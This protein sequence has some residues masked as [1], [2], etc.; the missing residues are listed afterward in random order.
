MNRKLILIT[1]TVALI[2]LN[3]CTPNSTHP[4]SEPRPTTIQDPLLLKGWLTLYDQ[5]EAIQ[6][7]DGSSLSGR[8]LAQFVIDHAIQMLWA[9][10]DNNSHSS[11]SVQNC[12]ND[13]CTKE[14]EPIYFSPSIATQE[15]DP[16]SWLV[17][18][19]AHEI[20]H[21]MQP[22]G[23][24]RDTLFEEFSAYYV[25]T[26]ISGSQW[27][28]FKEGDGLDAASLIRWFN[29]HRLLSTY[30]NFKLYP[31]KILPLVKQSSLVSIANTIPTDQVLTFDDPSALSKLGPGKSCLVIDFLG[32]EVCTPSK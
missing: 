26:R 14:N 24:V 17:E 21:E 32:N 7:P 30:R 5:Q 3:A 6:M 15:G 11:Y 2:C 10:A 9:P 8:V 16:L 25:S 20:Y 28:Q 22:F 23:Q 1:L 27:A 13:F 4:I 18:C 12:I 31:Q 29:D 19:M